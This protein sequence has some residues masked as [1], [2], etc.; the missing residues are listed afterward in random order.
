MPFSRRHHLSSRLALL[1]ED[2]PPSDQ[3]DTRRAVI[4]GSGLLLA[5]LSDGN[6]EPLSWEDPG[7]RMNYLL[8]IAA[9]HSEASPIHDT[10]VD[11]LGDGISLEKHTKKSYRLPYSRE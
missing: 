6:L 10:V 8:H 5:S 3:F 9:R 2:L 1:I 7:E 4:P 11:R